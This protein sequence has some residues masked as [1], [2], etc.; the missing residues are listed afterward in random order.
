M[1]NTDRDRHLTTEQLSALLDRQLSAEEQAACN[2]HLESCQQCQRALASLRQTVAL[3]RSMPQPAA[4]RSFALSPG[5]TYLQD[6]P[7]RQAAPANA[8]SQRRW[9]YYTR[10]SLRALSTIAAVIGFF[11]LLSGVLPMLFHGGGT[12]NSA[13]MAP[14]SGNA[15][16]PQL[17]ATKSAA[18]TTGSAKPT[19]N[20]KNTPG[21]KPQLGKTPPAVTGSPAAQDH[22]NKQLLPNQAQPAPPVIDLNEPLVRQGVGFILLVLGIVGFLLTR[23]WSSRRT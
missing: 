11:F 10:R 22:Q 14:S 9:P 18:A 2:A 20:D 6:A 16:Q 1:G 23:R 21:L 7:P 12:T 19:A 13:T 4:P 17:A 5:V 3:L 15:T 8:P